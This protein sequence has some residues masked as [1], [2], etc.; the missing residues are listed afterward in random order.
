M[1]INKKRSSIDHDHSQISVSRQCELLDLARSS[2]YYRPSRDTSYNELLMRLLDE[3]YMNT[4]FYG[5]DK[6]T[7]WLGRQ[8]HHVNPKRVRR[9]L[10]QMGIEAIYPRPNRNLSNP[11]KAHKIFPYLLKGVGIYHVDQVWSIDITYIRMHQGW[12]YLVA[13]IDWYS[14]YV[15]SWEISVTLEPLF[16]IEA[17]RR[18]LSERSPE[19]FNT[20]QGSQFTSPDFTNILLDRGI[21]VSMDGRGRCFDN[22]FIERLWRSVKVEEVYI[23]DY[24]TVSEANYYLSRYF[25][26]Y[27][28]ERLHASLGYQTPAEVY[29]GALAP[30]VALRAPSGANAPKSMISPSK[31]VNI[32]V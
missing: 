25:E 18:A 7:F 8:G 27:N 3:Q 21:K 16:C 30:P 28:N 11:N 23:R 26:F 29:F 14:R 2:L 24:D 10:R 20:D 13:V 6:M 12:V 31:N 17:L 4:P 32:F 22:I 5:V 19:I 9:L 1:T 15:L